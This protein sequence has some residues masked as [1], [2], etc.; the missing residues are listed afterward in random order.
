MPVNK[1]A[2]H[3]Q[4]PDT[5]FFLTISV[6]RLGVSAEKVV[7]TME[8]PNSHHGIFL[9]E[10]KNSLALLPAVLDAN[11]PISVEITKK[12]IIIAQSVVEIIIYGCP[13][14]LE[15]YNSIWVENIYS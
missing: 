1:N 6:T 9:P 13:R 11:N 12:P 10:R 15:N 14:R 3:T 8:T 5:P 7:A 4:L 2:H